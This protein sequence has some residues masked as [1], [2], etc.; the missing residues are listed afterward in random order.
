MRGQVSK[1]HVAVLPL[2]APF[3]T[4]VNAPALQLRSVVWLVGLT[5]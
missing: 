4:P 2:N 5:E 3:V 1:V